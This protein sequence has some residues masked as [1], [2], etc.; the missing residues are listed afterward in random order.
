MRLTVRHHTRY[1][2]A[3]PVKAA[4]QVLRLTPR[5]HDGQFVKAW[6]V[7]IDADCRLNREEDAYAN[8]THTFSLDGPL[9]EVNVHVEG[10]IQTTDMGGIVGGA[11]ERFPTAFWL[12]RS[13]LTAPTPAIE[14]MA[15]GVG[16]GEGGDPL[17]T[18]HALMATLNRNMRFVVGDTTAA[19][20][21]ADAYAKG[22]GVCQDFAQ[23]F[24]AAARELH[25]PARY[26]GGYY[27]R[28]DTTEQV[29]G[30]AWAEAWLP[31]IGWLGFD[32]T[33][34]VCI[35]ERYVR[36]ATGVDSLDA[37]PVRGVRVGGGGETL[38]VSVHVAMVQGMANQ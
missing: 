17:A 26:V 29:A 33:N 21:A 38:D 4:V 22:S 2:Y 11:P 15:R 10:S 24:V 27:L 5:N 12:R 32:P 8:I 28:T 7:E 14:A 13:A 35:D 18:L 31:D 36:V 23:V 37:S 6:R 30:H 3:E 19:T 25:I 1:T 34:G 16:A 20:T 9:D